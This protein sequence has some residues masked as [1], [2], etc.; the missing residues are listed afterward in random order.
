MR[1]RNRRALLY[2]S[3]HSGFILTIP[4]CLAEGQFQKCN[5]KGRL[6]KEP[7]AS[8]FMQERVHRG[9]GLALP[10]VRLWFSFSDGVLDFACV[11]CIF[12]V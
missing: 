11:L 12:Q 4:L 2:N 6:A 1:D 7:I 10:V 5:G 9:A 3:W 8:W